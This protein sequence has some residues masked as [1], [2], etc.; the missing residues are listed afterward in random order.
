LGEDVFR[1]GRNIVF[2]SWLINQCESTS[3]ITAPVC[4]TRRRR[5]RLCGQPGIK[6]SPF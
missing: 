2:H 1:K 5:R 6:Q 3:T 4:W